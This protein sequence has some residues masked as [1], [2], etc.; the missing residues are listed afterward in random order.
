LRPIFLL[1]T[2]NT[3]RSDTTWHS[4]IQLWTPCLFSCLVISLPAPR[5]K[6][7][8]ENIHILTEQ[9]DPEQNRFWW[10][11]QGWWRSPR[12]NTPN[13]PAN[14]RHKIPMRSR[15][16]RAQMGQCSFLLR[17]LMM[18]PAHTIWTGWWLWRQKG[19]R[20]EEA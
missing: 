9:T 4:L 2:Y 8:C 15:T 6:N 7:G 1:A 16:G 10:L 13:L 11:F 18:E 19:S 5:A 14:P 12:T 3:H 20:K 17:R